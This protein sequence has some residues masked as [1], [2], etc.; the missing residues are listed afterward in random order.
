MYTNMHKHT[1][2]R[3]LSL[4]RTHICS[5][6]TVEPFNVY[7]DMLIHMHNVSVN[8]N[9]HVLTHTHWETDRF[10]YTCDI[11]CILK[12]DERD[13]LDRGLAEENGLPGES[14]SWLLDARLSCISCRLIADIQW[15]LS[16][17]RLS[18]DR[19]SVCPEQPLNPVQSRDLLEDVLVVL[20]GGPANGGR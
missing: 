2:T 18:N 4:T 12:L 11:I 8:N 9:T 15:A 7:K 19:L 16:A 6:I 3:T 10:V 17:L 14:R 1:H 13:C 5:Q 20:A